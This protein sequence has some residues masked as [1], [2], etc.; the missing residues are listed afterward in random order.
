LR[1]LLSFAGEKKRGRLNL[2]RYFWKIGRW[3]LK[4]WW[5]HIQ[6]G[7]LKLGLFHIYLHF[8]VN[9]PIRNFS[10]GLKSSFPQNLV[11]LNWWILEIESKKLHLISRVA[12]D[13]GGKRT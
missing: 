4:S 11:Y 13:V 9:Q 8:C 2:L 10:T 5:I 6:W 1:N 12:P 3:C 7:F